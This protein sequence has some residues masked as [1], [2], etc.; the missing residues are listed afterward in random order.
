MPAWISCWAKVMWIENVKK[1]NVALSI[2]RFVLYS[3]EG[4][5]PIIIFWLS[6]RQI[7][8]LCCDSFDECWAV[9]FMEL[10]HDL[11]LT[12]N[13]VSSKWLISCQYVCVWVCVDMSV[14][15][16]MC[17]RAWL[18]LSVSLDVCLSVCLSLRM[19]VFQWIWWVGESVCSK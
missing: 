9:Y 5:L 16:C 18:R 10:W 15:L 13:I 3:C 14:R 6:W 19:G 1:E 8:Q 12:H 4:K 7:D 11:W 17:P 2:Y